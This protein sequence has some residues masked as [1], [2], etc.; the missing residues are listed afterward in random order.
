MLSDPDPLLCRV[1]PLQPTGATLPPRCRLTRGRASPAL[2]LSPSEG[3]GGNLTAATGV[4]LR[5]GD[6]NLFSTRRA[7]FKLLL[8]FS[9]RFRF[10]EEGAD[11]TG[12]SHS[13]PPPP[14]SLRE[15]LPLL[16]RDPVWVHCY[17]EVQ[18]SIRA[19]LAVQDL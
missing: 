8:L 14:V 6:L 3:A 7:Y 19:P 16:R 15:H 4:L 9:S 1:D 2:G 10:T 13:P 17:H 5:C 11:G 18:A 12:S